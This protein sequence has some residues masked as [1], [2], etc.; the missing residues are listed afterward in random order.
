MSLA[1]HPICQASLDITPIIAAEEIYNSI[2]HRPEM[3]VF[4][5]GTIQGMSLW[6]QLIF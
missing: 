5:F 6:L 2:H 3:K 1:A 4:I